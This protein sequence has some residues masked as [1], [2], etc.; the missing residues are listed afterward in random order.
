MLLE[1]TQKKTHLAVNGVVK[2]ARNSTSALE[3][4]HLAN[5]GLQQPITH[6]QTT[7][8]S[9]TEVDAMTYQHGDKHL[10]F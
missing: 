3:S 9:A 4:L 8:D 1:S 10:G 7:Q 2:L 6:D 5:V